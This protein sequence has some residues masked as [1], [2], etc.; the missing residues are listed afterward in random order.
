MALIICPECG[1]EISNK[2][3][4]CPYCGCPKSEWESIDIKLN[5]DESK[6][7]DYPEEGATVECRLNKV[8]HFCGE[9]ISIID[10]EKKLYS[11]KISKLRIMSI[12]KPTSCSYGGIRVSFPKEKP[13]IFFSGDSISLSFENKFG[14]DISKRYLAEK[15]EEYD[16]H[17]EYLNE[18]NRNAAEK[19]KK[20]KQANKRLK[21]V[22]HYPKCKSTNLQYLGADS[23]GGRE[24]KT[25]TTTSLNLNPLKPFTLFNHKE[26]I[27]KKGSAG[28]DFDR[29]RCEEC[30]NVFTTI[31]K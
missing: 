29:W 15:L 2:A 14:F 3:M 5:T 10:N 22:P 9:N 17:Q 4:Q 11:G 20:E 19:L 30:G 23:V 1:K 16:K 13:G 21:N 26:K 25:K 8:I 18:Y 28:I 6:K 12:E 24:T 31:K 7:F 27:V